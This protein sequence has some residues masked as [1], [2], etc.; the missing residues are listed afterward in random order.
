M[1]IS[2]VSQ[3]LM[4]DFHQVIEDKNGFPLKDWDSDEIRYLRP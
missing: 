2:T 1:H 4:A 3:G